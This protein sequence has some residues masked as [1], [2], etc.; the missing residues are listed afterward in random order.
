MIPLLETLPKGKDPAVIVNIKDKDYRGATGLSQSSIKDFIKSPAHYL[1]ATEQVSEPSPA[2]QL[3][4]AFHAVMLQQSPKEHYAVKIKMDGRT[5]DGKAYNEQFAI[6]NAGKAVITNED[7]ETLFKMRDSIL[8]HPL[9]SKLAKGLT[10]KEFAVFGSIET[11]DGYVRLKG[12]IDGYSETEGYILDYKT[13]E[14]AS[15]LGFIKAIRDRRYD[16]Q[17]VQY[18]W[19]LNNAR[20]KVKDF[21]FV[22]VE[23]VPPYAV[24]VY[25]IDI[26][27]LIAT[28]KKWAWAIGDFC[29]CQRDGKYPAYSDDCITLSLNR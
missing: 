12:L 18:P 9:A 5:K 1:V 20:M 14:D 13:C 24:G 16:I 29:I 22:C 28:G 3:G 21:Y 23:K 2:M 17:S 10:H 11:D 27:N 25:R 15:P 4:T 7:E 26:E 19:L 6:E 8:A